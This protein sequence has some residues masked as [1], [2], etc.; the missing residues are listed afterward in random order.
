MYKC[1]ICGKESKGKTCSGACRAKLSRQAHGQPLV[2]PTRTRTEGCKCALPGDED[3][4]GVC[5]KIDGQW[6]VVKPEPIP[7]K[8]M[9]RQELELAIR[10]YPN[11]QWVNSPEH[12]ELL[13]RLSLMSAEELEQQGY[14]IP[15]GKRAG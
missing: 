8:T 4:V 11:D 9:T 5:K 10:A 15:A 7:L 2:T 6:R 14:L 3:Y 12:K 13:S 1:M